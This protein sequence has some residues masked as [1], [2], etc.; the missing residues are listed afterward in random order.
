MDLRTIPGA[1]G[2]DPG[3]AEMS[4]RPN[5]LADAAATA[6]TLAL[7]AVT[8]AI[9]IGGS[10]S[11]YA[12]LEASARGLMVGAPIAVGLHARG[13]PAFHRFGNLLIGAGI[14]CFFASFSASDDGLIYS[15]GRISGWLVEVGLLYLVLAF[16][17]GSLERVDRALVSAIA[18]VILLL[19]L[20][21]A[22]LVEHYPTPSPW[23]ACGGDCPGNAFMATDAEPALVADLIRPVRET[24]MIAIFSAATVRLSLRIGHAS[25]IVRRTFAPVLTVATFRLA[26]V[27]TGIATSAL[28]PDAAFI[29]VVAWVV[30]LAVPVL[31]LAFLVGLI[32]WRL[33]IAVALERLALRLRAHPGPDVLR[34]AL[35]EAFEDPSLDVLYSLDEPEDHWTDA[36]GR[37]VD[38]ASLQTAAC[39]TEAV[40]DGR[41]VAVFI[42]DPALRHDDAFVDSATAYAAIALDNYRLS[43]QTSALLR[44]VHESRGRILAAADQERRRI[45][46][47]LHD[48]AQQRLVTLR[49]KLELAAER[50]ANGDGRDAELLSALGS[51]IDEALDEVRSLARGIYPA[52]LAAR[53]LVEALRAAALRAALPTAVLAAGIGRYP[54]EVE[55]A[56]YF[57]C[58]EALQ[59]ADKHAAGAT[60]AVIELTYNGAL[61]ME[62]RDD[63]AGFEVASVA[64]G[65]GFTS[66]RDRLAAVGGHL[67]VRSSAGRG[68]RV[69][70]A[71]PLG[72]DTSGA[73]GT[74]GASA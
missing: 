4:S 60:A 6:A 63:G 11:K 61:T 15:I 72:V 58:L 54:R 45:E 34:E 32:R 21:T 39:I 19:Y 40:D 48:G 43:A 25:H 14:G 55:S 56:A 31:A 68:T 13:L 62:V 49:I 26:A 67:E 47:D 1:H 10:T 41:R 20:P 64:G 53:G 29:D 36:S 2:R 27:A 3:N 46:H 28:A 51:E 16:P 65:V 5:S 69:R 18:L 30:A 42:H 12:A 17:S 8:A 22:L 59:N 7:C 57:C 50:S 35:A 38:P 66:M 71:I 44:E 33:F 73:P 37:A 24:L 52:S 74:S 23:T 70:A 9:T